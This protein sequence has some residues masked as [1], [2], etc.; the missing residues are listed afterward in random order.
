[1][2]LCLIVNIW[3]DWALLRETLKIMRPLVEGVLIIGST[4]SNHGEFSPIP[5][6]FHTDELHVREPKFHIPLHS[7]TDKRNYGLQIAKKQGYTH[8]LTADADEVY[9][10]EEFLKVKEHVFKSGINGVVCPS[11]VY[12]G[13]PKL[14]L[15]RD[16]TL[17]PHIHKLTPQIQHAFNRG[18]PFAWDRKQIRID[19]SRSLNINTG[20]EY[21][22]DVTL[23]HL[24]WVRGDYEKKIRNSTAR[25]NLERSNILTQVCHAKAGDYIDFY[26]RSLVPATVDFG[27][28]DTIF[29]TALCKD[30]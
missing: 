9:V 1:L 15:G 2:K 23:H 16:V 18:Y 4:R 25:A 3:D 6:D 7:E 30:L 24:S 13:S 20:V 10:A 22:E 14:S 12:F 8:F 28:N 21:T 19:P 5:S 27:I 17:V 29:K 26:K 11:I